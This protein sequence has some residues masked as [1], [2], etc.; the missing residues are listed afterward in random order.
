MTKHL[1][2]APAVI[3]LGLLLCGCGQKQGSE[4]PTLGAKIDQTSVSG[5]SSGA[6]MAG[7]FEIAH[8]TT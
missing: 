6:Y 8:A 3:A 1:R 5:I 7:Q 2:I 4:L